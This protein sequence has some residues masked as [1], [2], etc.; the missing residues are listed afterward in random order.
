LDAHGDSL[1]ALAAHGVRPGSGSGSDPSRSARAPPS[2][3]SRRVPAGLQ[4]EEDPH[5]VFLRSAQMQFFQS[6]SEQDQVRS[7]RLNFP[8]KKNDA[9][10]VDPV[11]GEE[12]DNVKRRIM[13]FALGFE[14]IFATTSAQLPASAYLLYVELHTAS[15]KTV[16]SRCFNGMHTIHDL[17]MWVYEK[18]WLPANAYK[19]SYAEPGKAELTD[20]LRLLTTND[21]LDTRTLSTT[22]AVHS[23]Y[24]GIP[25]VHAITD[26]GVTRLYLRLRCRTCGNL[27]NKL[28]TCGRKQTVMKHI[29]P[30]PDILALPDADAMPKAVPG[31]VMGTMQ[32]NGLH[33][34]QRALEE[35]AFQRGVPGFDPNIEEMW[36]RPD[37]QKHC[38]FHGRGFELYEAAR[39]HGGHAEI[40]RIYISCGKEPSKK[41]KFGTM[42]TGPKKAIS[43]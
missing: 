19:L 20:Q 2:A 41:L 29:E 28:Q 24:Q 22:R 12:Q 33:N 6:S 38:L 4:D 1:D 14:K 42:G 23:M 10:T 32:K 34:R 31:K 18:L 5:A 26:I 43:Y 16:F 17:K 7:A 11:T 25:G 40:A 8:R 36:H 35:N 27:L 9:V 15:D 30:G 13:G 3:G 21:S 39:T 37:G